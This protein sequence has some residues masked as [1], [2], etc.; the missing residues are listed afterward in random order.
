MKD[1]ENFN[2]STDEFDTSE[3]TKAYP[4]DISAGIG[5]SYFSSKYVDQGQKNAERVTKNS[6][7][8]L[9]ERGKKRRI[10][11]MVI[12]IVLSVIVTV[13]F[14]V[15]CISLFFIT[16]N[17]VIEGDTR[18]TSEEIIAISG[19]EYGKNLY[20]I[21]KAAIEQQLISHLPYIKDVKIRRRVPDTI[22]II[23]E[24]DTPVYY[25]EIQGEYF[26]ISDTLRVLERT[27]DIAEM[28]VREPDIIKL[29][30]QTITYAVE[31]DPI[32]FKNE[33]YYTYAQDMLAT[34]LE[35]T[36]GDKITLIDFSDKFSIY[37]MYEKRLRI[38][39][40]DISDIDMKIRFADGIISSLDKNY[41]G[42]VNVEGYPAF[43]IMD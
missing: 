18:Y 27:D 33:G 11:R 20:D 10:R 23:I 9:L 8:N 29:N 24:E 32:V 37:V 30:T 26:M 36:I 40:G 15:A 22:A 31:G 43:F 1:N 2:T 35:S 3:I 14:A 12:T 41:S 42:T 38:E 6:F 13:I 39:V 5:S 34:F 7:E 19:I 21:D 28:L 4:G 17:I 25:F 16:E